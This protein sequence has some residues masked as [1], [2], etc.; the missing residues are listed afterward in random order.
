MGKKKL[1]L[2][3]VISWTAIGLGIIVI[4]LVLYKIIIG[5]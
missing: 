3:K 1:T 5:L 2:G 4:V